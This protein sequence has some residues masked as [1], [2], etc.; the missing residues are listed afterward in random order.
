MRYFQYP[1]SIT[2]CRTEPTALCMPPGKEKGIAGIPSQ[3]FPILI[4]RDGWKRGI[5]GC[6]V[7][8][9]VSS[10]VFSSPF[11]PWG[12]VG[13]S[14]PVSRRRKGGS[15]DSCSATLFLENGRLYA[16]PTYSCAGMFSIC[17]VCGFSSLHVPLHFSSRLNS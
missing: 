12:F 4:K 9:C 6:L 11:S 13:L 15:E 17:K 3:L 1:V 10:H 2:T 14:P 16:S 8:R 7:G 5:R